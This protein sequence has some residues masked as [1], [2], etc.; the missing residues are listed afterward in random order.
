[1]LSFLF[2]QVPDD[3]FEIV[4]VIPADDVDSSQDLNNLLFSLETTTVVT[5]IAQRYSLAFVLDLSSSLSSLVR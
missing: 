5:F 2:F 3:E 4:S 1:M